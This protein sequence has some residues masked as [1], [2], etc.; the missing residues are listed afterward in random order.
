MRIKKL[1]YFFGLS[2]ILLISGCSKQEE[3]KE[4]NQS[5]YVVIKTSS[6]KSEKTQTIFLD[7]DMNYIGEQEYD[8]GNVGGCGYNVPF[9]NDNKMYDISL[10]Y[11]DDAAPSKVLEISMKDL[12]CKSFDFDRTNITDL[13]VTD[14]YVYALSNLNK[15]TYIDRCPINGNKGDIDTIEIADETFIYLYNVGDKVFVGKKESG[16]NLYQCDFEKK[17]ISSFGVIEEFGGDE[18]IFSEEYGKELILAGNQQLY[19]ISIENGDTRVVDIP[20][21]KNEIKSLYLD[22]DIL[23]VSRAEFHQQNEDTVLVKYDLEENKILDTYALP[24][25]L[26]QFQVKDNNI[27][28]ITEESVLKYS[29]KAGGEITKVGEYQVQVEGNQYVSSGYFISSEER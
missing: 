21:G 2:T 3:S 7:A 6:L 4:V 27:V 10:A 20:D 1:I 19:F 14:R 8:Y 24:T 17:E 29:M 22:A 12:I 15:V 25:S 18:P 11:G 9:I 5:E 16:L 26:M 23:Y 28:V 13:V